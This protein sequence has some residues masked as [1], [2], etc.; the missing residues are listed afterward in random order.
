MEELKLSDRQCLSKEFASIEVNKSVRFLTLNMFL[1]PPGI[2]TDG[3][4]YKEARLKYFIEHYLNRFDVI[5]F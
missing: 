4:D 3:D 1:R 5:S 2:T